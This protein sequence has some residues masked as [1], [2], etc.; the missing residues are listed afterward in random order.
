MTT[1]LALIMGPP[2]SDRRWWDELALPVGD[3][4][5]DVVLVSDGEA[6]VEVGFARPRGRRRPTPPASWK[7]DPSLLAGA[8]DQLRRYAAG[9]LTRFEM[10]L[11]PAGTSFQYQVWSELLTIE[12]GTTTTYGRIARD[13]G[14]PDAARAVGAAVGANPLAIVVPCHRVIGADGS[15]TGYA[16]G[17]DR[18][19]A[20]L[21]L[22]GVLAL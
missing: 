11:R 2:A 16:G 10:A 15:L 22:E 7:R 20:L 8:A 3:S 18:K 19:V 14:L 13:L 17:L 12:Y 1:P 5:L 6:L 4:P 9:E 21:R